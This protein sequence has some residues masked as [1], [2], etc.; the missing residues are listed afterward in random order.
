[1]RIIYC[2]SSHFGLHSLEMLR[3]SGHEIVHIITQ[4]AHRAGRGRK[5]TP[6]PVADWASEHRIPCT[7]AENI[8]SP[9]ILELARSL[10]PD[11]YIVIAFGQKIGQEFISIARYRA[12]NVHASLLPKY[13]GA[14]PIN[15]A[16]VNGETE[17]GVTIITLAE[18]M[19]AGEMLG[20]ASIPIGPEDNAQIVHDNLALI[21]APLLLET[22]EKIEDGT[23]VY[24]PQDESLV[25]L[26]K[27]LKKSDGNINWHS[28]AEE[29]SRHIRGFWPWPGA[30]SNYVVAKTGKCIKITIADASVTIDDDSVTRV[31][32]RFDSNMNVMCGEGTLEIKVVKPAGSRAMAFQ[33]FLNGRET[34]PDDLFMDVD[35]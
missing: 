4:P 32:G 31:V 16:I 23:A 12:I 28:S 13:R 9:D 30:F 7:E 25:T 22:L 35:F 19:D 18:R 29:I 26:A 21:A 24:E 33:S 8:N 27:K 17:T 5:I 2:G 6:T 15:W 34:G 10:K 3:E 1:M 14:A 11:I 20:K